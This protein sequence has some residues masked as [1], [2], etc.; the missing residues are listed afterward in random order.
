MHAGTVEF[1][2]SLI[3][4]QEVRFDVVPGHRTGKSAAENLQA[5]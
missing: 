5:T 3:E 4:D 1:C 2:N